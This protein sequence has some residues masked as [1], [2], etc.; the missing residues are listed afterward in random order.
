M[1]VAKMTRQLSRATVKSTSSQQEGTCSGSAETCSGLSS[2]YAL[3][4]N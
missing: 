4:V 2:S 1:L 3:F